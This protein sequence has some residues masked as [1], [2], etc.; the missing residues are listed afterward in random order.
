MC[1]LS[2]VTCQMS[3]IMC[4]VSCVTCHLSPDHHSI[5][6]ISIF[7]KVSPKHSACCQFF[8]HGF[9]IPKLFCF[10]SSPNIS[11][12]GKFFRLQWE[13]QWEMDLKI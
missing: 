3:H 1:Q 11:G 8:L 7:I 4:Q 12:E 13:F 9:L 10:P 6:S 2:P 5:R